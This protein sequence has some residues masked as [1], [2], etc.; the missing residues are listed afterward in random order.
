MPNGREIVCQGSDGF[1]YS[2]P[3][4]FSDG[5]VTGGTPRRLTHVRLLDTA[6]HSWALSPDGQRML[7][8]AAPPGDS[9]RVLTVVTNYAS[10][11]RRKVEEAGGLR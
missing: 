11:L 2:V 4:D 9:A 7:F 8:V 6:G 3:L 10:L 5:R 1:L